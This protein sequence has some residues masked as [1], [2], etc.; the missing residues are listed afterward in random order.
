MFLR[1]RMFKDL[2]ESA[3]KLIDFRNGVESAEANAT[4]AEFF[5][6]TELFMRQRSAM[7]AGAHADTVAVKSR[8]KF[9]AWKKVRGDQ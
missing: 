8:G 4:S 9:F 7:K 5:G 6:S 1:L 3:A 2:L